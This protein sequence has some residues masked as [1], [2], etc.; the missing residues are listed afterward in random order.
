MKQQQVPQASKKKKSKKR[1]H[2]PLED[3]QE[4][5]HLKMTLQVP[6]STK[7]NDNH[8]LHTTKKCIKNVAWLSLNL[9]NLFTQL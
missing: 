6:G 3:G 4:E 8:G 7:Q 1:C 5:G 2:Q 9:C